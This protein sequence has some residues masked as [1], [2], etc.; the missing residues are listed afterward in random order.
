VKKKGFYILCALLFMPSAAFAQTYSS[1]SYQVNEATFGS[2]GNV[3]ANSTSYNARGSVGNL[4]VGEATSASYAAFAGSVTPD[5]EYL[6]LN[7]TFANVD[8]GT[9]TTSTTGIGVSS[10]YVRTYLNAG[11]VVKTMSQ[12]P[13]NGTEVLDAMTT[14][15][16]SSAGT[17]Q[18]GI[19]LVANTSPTNGTFPSGA[20]SN[21]SQAPSATFANGQAATGY[22]TANTYK[23]TAGDTIAS[24]SSARAWGQTNYT[25]SYIAN[26]S[27]ITPGGQYSVDHDIVVVP[28]Y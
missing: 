6:E 12:P 13:A 11:Y 2:G 27:A 5:A 17:E 20:G 7:V 10:F 21:P 19:N 8:L 24:N 23:Y 25:I 28:T 16:A 9:L 18:F 26:V 4:G 14:A 22:N 15:G 1:S 3:D